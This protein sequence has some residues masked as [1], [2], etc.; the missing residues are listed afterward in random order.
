MVPRVG[1]MRQVGITAATMNR[2]CSSGHGGLN[3]ALIP[4]MAPFKI[5][6]SHAPFCL[7]VMYNAMAPPRD[8][9]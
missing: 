4:H 5:T 9:A 2:R 6:P 1:T 8:S 3:L 7:S